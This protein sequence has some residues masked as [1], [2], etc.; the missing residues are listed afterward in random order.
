MDGPFRER[1]SA[2]RHST[3]HP[4]IIT[5]TL[6]PGKPHHRRSGGDKTCPADAVNVDDSDSLHDRSPSLSECNIWHPSRHPS[7]WRP[8]NDA[9]ISPSYKVISRD[10]VWK[11]ERG[12]SFLP[13]A[14]RAAGQCTMSLIQSEGWRRCGVSFPFSTSEPEV[15][16]WVFGVVKIC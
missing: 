9:C 15:G 3:L 11:S 12:R 5:L 14:D 10:P 2:A 6:S 8:N 1:T 7:I 13:E 16:F 4:L